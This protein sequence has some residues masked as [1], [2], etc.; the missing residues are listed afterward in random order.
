M[1]ALE[2]VMNC[3]VMYSVCVCELNEVFLVLLVIFPCYTTD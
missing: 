1:G 2:N 3:I